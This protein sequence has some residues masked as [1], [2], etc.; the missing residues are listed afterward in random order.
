MIN[1]DISFYPEE[2]RIYVHTLLYL[3]GVVIK[4][5]ILE[6]GIYK[7]VQKWGWDFADGRYF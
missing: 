2:N 6:N 1:I 3:K 4:A 5:L 7:E